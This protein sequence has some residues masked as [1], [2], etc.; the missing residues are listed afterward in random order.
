VPLITRHHLLILLVGL[1]LGCGEEP[2][3]VSSGNLHVTVTGLPA[4]SSASLLVSGP[5]GY[6]QAVTG[7]QTLSSLA[8]GTYTVVASN[9][10]LGAATYTAA[11]ASQ[12][13]AVGSSTA[14]ATVVYSTGLGAL[15]I[16]INGL[17]TSSDAVVTIAGPN[18][19]SR[20]VSETETL[21]GL[22]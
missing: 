3:G 17:G 21:T 11:P 20:N 14:T 15:S 4:G 12:T 10:N 7:T 22:A 2:S 18:A 19:Y 8:P 6:T 9:V 5:G 13:V 1:A 16:T